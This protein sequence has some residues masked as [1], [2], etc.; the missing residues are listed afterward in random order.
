VNKFEATTAIAHV[1][2]SIIT[3]TSRHKYFYAMSMQALKP[4]LAQIIDLASTSCSSTAVGTVAAAFSLPFIS[5]RLNKP[6]ASQAEASTFSHSVS[7]PECKIG[8]S[9]FYGIV[10]N[11]IFNL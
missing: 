5:R 4:G 2:I 7:F 3:A 6:L 11:I 9:L 1:H 8:V 10:I